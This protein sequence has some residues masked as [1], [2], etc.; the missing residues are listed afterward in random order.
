M[1]TWLVIA[2]STN[3]FIYDISKPTVPKPGKPHY[4]LLKEL[5]H[6]ESRSKA[7][8]LVSDGPGH[9]KSSGSGKGAFVAHADPHENEL[10]SFAKEIAHH[11]EAERTKNSYKQLV[12]CA[13]PHFHG[14]LDQSL[15]K[16]TGLLVKKHIQKDYVPLSKEQLHEVIEKIYHEPL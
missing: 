13:A 12:I 8:E 11:L 5:A 2:S 4:Q 15:S 1:S 9:Y 10:N 7:S 3:A 6:P 16:Q 14:L